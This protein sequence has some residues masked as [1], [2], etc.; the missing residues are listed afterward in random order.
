MDNCKDN[1]EGMTDTQYRGFLIDQLKD[2]EEVLKL[3]DESGNNE[4]QEKA[5]QHIDTIIMKLRF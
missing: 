2:W 4:I 3:A 5:Q 1:C